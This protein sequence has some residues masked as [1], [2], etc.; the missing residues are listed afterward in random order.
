MTKY[1]FLLVALLVAM[2]VLALVGAALRD[3][4][5]MGLA[6]AALGVYILSQLVNSL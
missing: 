5:W 4:R 3:I 2:V 1:E 6:L